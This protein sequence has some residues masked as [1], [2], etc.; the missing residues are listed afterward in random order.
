MVDTPIPAKPPD[1]SM[2]GLGDHAPPLQ[3][4]EPSPDPANRGS[5]VGE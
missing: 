5:L 1:E 2:E 4:P 3:Q